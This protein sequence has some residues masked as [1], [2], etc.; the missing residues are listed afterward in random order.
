MPMLILRATRAAASLV[1]PALAWLA[2]PVWAAA[3][4]K[5]SEIPVESF[6]RHAGFTRMALSPDA[7]KLAAIV[8]NNGRGNLVVIDLAKSTRNVITNFSSIDV[9]QFYWVDNQRLC[10]R[11]A[12]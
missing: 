9:A 4:Q 8:P 2:S 11:V 3:P 7:G 1:L 5:P 6:Y 10:M 12:D